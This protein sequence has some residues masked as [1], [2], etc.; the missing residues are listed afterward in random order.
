MPPL[1]CDPCG[2]AVAGVARHFDEAGTRMQQD[3]NNATTK[4]FIRALPAQVINTAGTQVCADNKHDH[5]KG[6]IELAIGSSLQGTPAATGTTQ[7]ARE[8]SRQAASLPSSASGR[9]P[10]H[11]AR[12]LAHECVQKRGV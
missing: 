8:A 6:D 7:T 10:E 2:I 12:S 11:Q 3:G 1:I 9:E 5:G 4:Q